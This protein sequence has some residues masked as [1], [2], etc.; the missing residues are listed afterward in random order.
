MTPSTR[1]KTKLNFCESEI[2]S[3]EDDKESTANTLAAVTADIGKKSSEVVMLAD[4]V[5][6]L[7]ASIDQVR[8]GLEA[9]RSIR[10]QEKAAFE[11]GSKDRTLALKVLKQA[12]DILQKF[13]NHEDQSFIQTPPHFRKARKTVATFG[14]V[15]IVQEITDD[16]AKEQKDAAIQETQAT[17]SFEALQTDS[18]QA[19]DDKQQ[20]ITDRVKAKAKR[21]VQINTL[22]ETQKDKAD[23]L[24]ALTGQLVLLHQQC[25]EILEHFGARKKVR[26][27]EVSQLRDVMD[28]L[29][30]SSIAARTGFLQEA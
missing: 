6:N 2:A 18:R 22:K 11:A 3:K 19:Q 9:A 24:N 30:G 7:Y 26:S 15:S 8:R 14:A 12:I 17:D 16:I 10:K 28:I 5:K 23:D 21:G 13:Y 27:F 20:V 1:K 25:D 29:S 4:E